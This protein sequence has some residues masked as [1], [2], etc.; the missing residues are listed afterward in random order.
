MAARGSTVMQFIP[1]EITQAAALPD[2]PTVGQL[3]QFTGVT[4][5]E[6]LMWTGK[7]INPTQRRYAASKSGAEVTINDLSDDYALSVTVKNIATQAGI[8]TAS[9]TNIRAIIRKSSLTAR[10]AGKNLF[11]TRENQTING[12]TKNVNSDGGVTL[13]GT[14]SAT[15]WFTMNLPVM[16]NGVLIMSANN[17]T[18]NSGV[19]IRVG[20]SDSTYPIDLNLNVANKVSA[21]VSV[22]NGIFVDIRVSAGTVLSNFVIKPQLELGAAATEFEKY[23]ATDYALTPDAA[24]C[25]YAGSEDEIGSDGHVTHRTVFGQYNGTEAWAVT[26]LTG[27]NTMRFNGPAITTGQNS[28]ANGLCSH[29]GTNHKSSMYASD[30]EG[31]NFESNRFSIRINKTRL[32]GYTAGWTDAQAL[33]AFK[34]LLG[35]WNTA[36]T[37]I[38]AVAALSTPITATVTPVEING[39]DGANTVTS[40]GASVAVGYTGSGWA[41]I[42]RVQRLNVE[43]VSVSPEQGLR[44]DTVLTSEDGSQ[45]V[46]TYFNARGTKFGLFNITN[47]TMI[48][49]AGVMP[50]GRGFWA[51]N[52]IKDP[53][54]SSDFYAEVATQ[55]DTSNTR[56]MLNFSESGE[57][58]GGVGV[59]KMNASNHKQM[60]IGGGGTDYGILIGTDALNESSSDE[61]GWIG[62]SPGQ[63]EIGAYWLDDT[64]I[65]HMNTV[66]LGG[67]LHPEGAASFT[68]HVLP[69]ETNSYSLGAS[70]VNLRWK[71]IFLNNNP[72]VSSDERIKQDIKPIEGA[73]ALLAAIPALEFRMADDPGKRH[74]GTTWQAVRDAL[75]AAGIPDAAILGDDTDDGSQIHGLLYG[76]FTGLLIAAL[77][78]HRARIGALEKRLSAPEEAG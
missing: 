72:N 61:D 56:L 60:F 58:V 16:L 55:S 62:I 13:N 77:A 51:S 25:G 28:F 3:V 70:S 75:N 34:T 67:L 49:G 42:G 47:D 12:V 14:A 20:K 6:L 2:N 63:I 26:S 74:Y 22:A 27:T 57:S 78:E 10:R 32:P 46:N 52:V 44:V 69:D 50:D 4:P 7:G 1:S 65:P 54:V 21:A 9:P 29:F 64:N 30:T 68:G 19:S 41:A 48:A 76:E 11:P 33:A 53:S 24:F 23:A 71:N 66:T 39:A 17:P 18:A 45:S 37:P 36:G 31:W 35:T 38:Q 40:D 43:A 5:N 8:G 59:M 73:D 15:T